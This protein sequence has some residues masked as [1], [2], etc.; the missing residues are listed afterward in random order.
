MPNVLQDRMGRVLR[1]LRVSLTDR[2][3]FRCRY[4]MPEKGVSFIDSDRTLDLNDF[5]QLCR[6]F[7]QAGIRRFKLTGGEPLLFPRLEDLIREIR[8]W[9][10]VEDLSLTTNGSLLAPKLEALKNAG[11]QRLTVSLDA[12]SPEAFRWMTRTGRFEKVWEAVQKAMQLGFHPIKINCV[13]YRE[14]TEEYLRLA[15]LAFEY[16][17]EI[18]FIEVMPLAE[19]LHTKDSFLSA[20][21]LRELLEQQWGPL[22]AIPAP[23]S[24]PARLFTWPKALGCIGFIASVTEPFCGNCDRLRLRSDGFLQLCLAHPNGVDLKPFLQPPYSF[25]DFRCFLEKAVFH[26]PA[27]HSFGE[28]AAPELWMSRIGG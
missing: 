11:L 21:E 25:E 1:T 2:C 4:C 27:G 24:A 13:T 14:I 19:K 10:E 20:S 16:P 28:K 18:R 17:F 7:V 22:K 8:G 23:P 26:K 6:W 15:Q 12:L 5:L 9:K 3:N